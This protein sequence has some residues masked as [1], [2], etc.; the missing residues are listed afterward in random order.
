MDILACITVNLFAVF[1]C[2]ERPEFPKMN[3]FAV[4]FFSV[5]NLSLMFAKRQPFAWT[6]GHAT[7]GNSPSLQKYKIQTPHRKQKLEA[8]ERKPGAEDLARIQDITAK[9]DSPDHS[10]FNAQVIRYPNI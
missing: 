3:G 10:K 8:E 2:T 7:A 5:S 1:E 9:F 6:F 4:R